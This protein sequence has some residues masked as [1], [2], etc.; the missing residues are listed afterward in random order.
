MS[1]IHGNAVAF[2]ADEAISNAL[3]DLISEASQRLILVSPY[4]RHWSRL[5]HEIVAAQE[6]GVEVTIYYRADVDIPEG[7]YG[8]ITAIPVPRLVA[9]IYAS[10][11]QALVGSMHLDGGSA[12]YSHNAGLLVRA[13]ELLNEIEEYIN[14]LSN[15]AVSG[16]SFETRATDV[17]YEASFHQVETPTDIARVISS[18]GFCI[19]C[20]RTKEFNHGKPLCVP[21]YFQYRTRGTH[22]FCHAC[23]RLET[24]QLHQPL[25]RVCRGIRQPMEEPCPLHSADLRESIWPIAQQLPGT[26]YYCPSKVGGNC[27]LLVHSQLGILRSSGD[28]RG[29][30]PAGKLAEVYRAAAAELPANPRYSHQ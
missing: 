15:S 28:P 23:G 20:G 25:C 16:P 18:S 3:I 13:P 7:T 10:E 12:M 14:L 5:E 2:L 19:E 21:C 22:K 26:F 8:A 1:G 11:S 29:Q 24:T 30:V 4:H 9:R 17:P 6:R 27:S